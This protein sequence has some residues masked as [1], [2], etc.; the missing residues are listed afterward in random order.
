MNELP[1]QIS[2]DKDRY[3]GPDERLISR[4][5]EHHGCA[6]PALRV[7]D[8]VKV[9]IDQRDITRWLLLHRCGVTEEREGRKARTTGTREERAW[10]EGCV[11][12]PKRIGFK[13]DECGA[14]RV[15]SV[16]IS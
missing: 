3:S 10:L 4:S 12:E 8:V 14:V 5:V 16:A 6:E 7:A 11:G 13:E 2:G 15:I 1:V 9:S